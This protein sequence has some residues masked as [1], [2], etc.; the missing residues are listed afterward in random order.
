MPEDRTVASFR[1]VAARVRAE[2][3]SRGRDIDPAG[4]FV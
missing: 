3:P 2:S 1:P 4:R